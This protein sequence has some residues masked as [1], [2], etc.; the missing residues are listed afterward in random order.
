LNPGSF[1]LPGGYGSFDRT[2]TTT[3]DDI[4]VKVD[5]SRVVKNASTP[6]NAATDTVQI[7]IKT[8][9]DPSSGK[10]T[11]T[12]I[13]PV[14]GGSADLSDAQI[15]AIEA[16]LADGKGALAGDVS[17]DDQR[18]NTQTTYKTLLE[19]DANGKLQS[20]QTASTDT[21]SQQYSDDVKSA[22]SFDA[23]NDTVGSAADVAASLLEKFTT[24]DWLHANLPGLGI[25]VQA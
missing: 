5:V 16:Q 2:V 8:V 13:D 25:S 23:S 4:S 12:V 24:P 3:V 7:Q 21:S 17:I 20:V 19:P 22:T 18:T 11:T 6:D 15:S 10:K 1:V 14:T 9:Y